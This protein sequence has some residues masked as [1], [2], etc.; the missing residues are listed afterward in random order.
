MPQSLAFL[1]FLAELGLVLCRP[2][3][4]LSVLI[5]SKRGTEAGSSLASL[6][7]LVCTQVIDPNTAREFRVDFRFSI[8]STADIVLSSHAGR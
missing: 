1:F 5:F 2:S 8:K 3:E 4:R 6:G 7:K